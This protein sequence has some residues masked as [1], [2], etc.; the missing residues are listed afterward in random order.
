M[1]IKIFLYCIFFVLN[2]S[3]IWAQDMEEK[4]DT[5][6]LAHL[7]RGGKFEG[8]MRTYGMAT[9][10]KD[11]LSDHYAIA[12]GGGIGYESPLLWKYFSF[13]ISGKFIYNLA[14]TDLGKPD[15][16]TQV[17][18]RYEIALFDLEN[19]ENR[20]EFDR[21]DE[22]NFRFHLNSKNT[23]TVGRQI[24]NSPLINP[25][26]G[27]M[28]PSL[29]SGLWFNINALHHTTFQGGWLWAAA[30]R[31][32][33][34]WFSVGESIGVYSNGINPDGSKGNYLGNIESKGI[35]VLGSKSTF[36]KKNTLEIWNYFI[37]NVSNTF[38][39]RTDFTTPLSNPTWKIRTAF[40][41][42][43]QDA[44]NNGGN[45]NQHKTYMLKGEKSWVFGARLGIEHENSLFLVNYTRITAD[46]RFLFPREWGRDPLLTF[47]QRERNE[48]AGDVHAINATWTQF[49]NQKEGR[50]FAGLGYY[51]MPDVK[52]THLNKYSLPSYIQLNISYLHNFKGFFKNMS[53]E[54]L[55]VHKWNRGNL[56]DNEKYRI[57]KVD[58]TNYNLILNYRF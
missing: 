9:T 29:M 36:Y 55:I 47:M 15:S 28:R 33:V 57:N 35:F 14:S 5:N 27:R 48:G 24:I 34:R 37:E 43:K 31:S 1:K 19:P 13:K 3:T 40:Q 52:N 32:T 26:D 4:I 41:L 38:F 6:S 20:A 21:M 25:Q 10:N 7:L 50:L 51:K 17:K 23:F 18:D 22:F 56:Y 39:F 44:I 45:E 30:P 54:A 8:E 49:F 2:T 11:M 46:G 16:T 42:I 12:L 58:M 53:L